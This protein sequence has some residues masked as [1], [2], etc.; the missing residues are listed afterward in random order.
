[1][2]FSGEQSDDIS[3]TSRHHRHRGDKSKNEGRHHLS[4]GALFEH[5]TEVSGRGLSEIDEDSVE[6]FPKSTSSETALDSIE[7]DDL[8]D[9]VSVSSGANISTQDTNDA[10]IVAATPSISGGASISSV[11]FHI[12]IR[13][14]D[15]RLTQLEGRGLEDKTA[16]MILRDLNAEGNHVVLCTPL[17]RSVL[18]GE[19]IPSSIDKRILETRP[20]DRYIPP[21]V[22]L[23]IFPSPI[24]FIYSI[25]VEVQCDSTYHF[26]NM[27][28][29]FESDDFRSEGCET[30]LDRIDNIF[31]FSHSDPKFRQNGKDISREVSASALLETTK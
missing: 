25:F 28:V 9:S 18:E 24:G 23:H 31:P 7:S 12:T 1:L 11:D 6:D 13:L 16:S 27:C 17:Y 29:D 2:D 5:G 22:F 10:S 3:G 4:D 15:G 14:L 20:F 21:T 30:I 8:G 26:P 19:V